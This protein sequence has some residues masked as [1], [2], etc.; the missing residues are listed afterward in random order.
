MGFEFAGCKIIEEEKGL[1]SLHHKIIDAH[2]DEIDTDCVVNAG[3]DGDFDFCAHSVIG[4]NEDWVLETRGLQ[5]EQAA[6]ATD[7]RVGTRPPR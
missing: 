5:I 3:F 6:E 4:R 2:G 7:F 1:G